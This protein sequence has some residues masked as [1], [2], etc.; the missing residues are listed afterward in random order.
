MVRLLNNNN[1]TKIADLIS[2]FFKIQCCMTQLV[3]VNRPELDNCIYAV[4]HAHQLCLYGLRDKKNVNIMISHS[5]DGEVIAKAIDKSFG[6]KAVRGSTGRQGA[7]EAT[8]KMIELLKNGEIGVIM[9]DG[10][11]GPVKK[12]KKGIIKIAKLSG[13]PIVPLYWYSPYPNFLKF[14]TWDGFRVPI[15]PA[16][17]INIY[18]DPIYVPADG[19]KESDEEVRKKLQT[20]MEDI[21]RRA[22]EEFNKV[23]RLGI[24]RRK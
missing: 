5:K 19:D 13:V 8:M 18:G 24:W 11:R 4:W 16:N 15:L 1:I 21:E 17:T 20:S 12:V 6:Y 23:Y 14:G 3:N 7:V 22:P 2:L 9:V 10:P